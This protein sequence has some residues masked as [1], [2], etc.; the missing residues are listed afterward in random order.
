MLT[1]VIDIASS[2]GC[3]SVITEL[4]PKAY[5]HNQIYHYFLW[6]ISGA[7]LFA[8]FDYIGYNI[9]LKKNWVNIKFVNPYRIS[10]FLF[11]I[12][13]SL[14][15]LIFIGWQPMAG[16]NIIWW[17]WGCDLLF[18]FYCASLNIFGDRGNFTKQVLGNQTTWA[19]WTP[20]GFLFTKKGE[21]VKWQRLIIQAII[22]LLLTAGICAM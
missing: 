20:Y 13:I 7:A 19:W 10:Q 17:F 21:P 1:K 5:M 9:S 2:A 18:Y 22:G 16:F 14:L 15:L 3:F 11:Q 6:S 4:M 12:I 8:L